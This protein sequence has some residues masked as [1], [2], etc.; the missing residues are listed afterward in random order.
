METAETTSNEETLQ[1]EAVAM[2]EINESRDGIKFKKLTP[3]VL[4][5][6]L[7]HIN[8][9]DLRWFWDYCQRGDPK[10]SPLYPPQTTGIFQAFLVGWEVLTKKLYIFY[11]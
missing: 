5:Y 1:E 4:G 2:E 11:C 10:K 6:K 8:L 9:E 3:Q 7:A